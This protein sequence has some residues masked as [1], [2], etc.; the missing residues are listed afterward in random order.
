MSASTKIKLLRILQYVFIGLIVACGIKLL[1]NLSA[2]FGFSGNG[3]FIRGWVSM[4]AEK[5]PAGLPHP[6]GHG[7]KTL[8]D[9]EH[10]KLVEV[11][12]SDMDIILK[13]RYIGYII[14]QSF[15]WLLGIIV[16]YQMVRILRNLDRGLLMH[17]ENA[18][19]IR[20]IALGVFLIPVAHYIA[21]HILAGI[22]YTFHGHEYATSVPA[23]HTERILV[24]WLVALLIFALG[25]AFRT[26]VELKQEHDISI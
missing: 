12:F 13:E 22:S 16:L 3:P 7:N 17:A 6:D 21:S 9:F 25:E 2:N 18:K 11:Q 24:D 10:Q 23:A 19:R 20:Y 14:F 5:D 15:T 26:S 4:A 1:S 8:Y